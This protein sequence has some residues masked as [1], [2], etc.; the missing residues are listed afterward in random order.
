MIAK[1]AVFRTLPMCKLYPPSNMMMINAI[2]AKYGTISIT[3]AGCII[4]S[5]G[6]MITPRTIKNAISGIP[7]FLKNASPKTPKIITTLAAKSKTGADAISL[8]SSAGGVAIQ[9]ANTSLGIKIAT[10][11]SAVPVTIGHGTSETTIS[12]S[13]SILANIISILYVIILCQL[14]IGPGHN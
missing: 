7:V 14:L 1:C 13:F 9:S 3:A 8:W 11:T 5:I 10:G 2:A 4:P 6:P 12:S